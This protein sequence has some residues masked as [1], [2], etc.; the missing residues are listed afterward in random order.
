MTDCI[1]FFRKL[2]ILSVSLYLP[3]QASIDYSRIICCRWTSS[4]ANYLVTRRDLYSIQ[5]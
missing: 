1:G 5:A 2:A 4:L 3:L